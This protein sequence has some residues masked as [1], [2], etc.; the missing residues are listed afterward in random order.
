MSISSTVVAVVVAALSVVGLMAVV[1]VFVD[2]L[3][4]PRAVTAAVV[5]R[6]AEGLPPPEVLDLY[7]GEA[8]RHPARRRGQRPLLLVAAS[9][10]PPTGGLT[11]PLAMV[12][13]RYDAVLVSVPDGELE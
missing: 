1:R 4:S 10:L 12:A 7:L 6:A 8:V 13:E 5:L 11:E 2:A 3:W 9:L